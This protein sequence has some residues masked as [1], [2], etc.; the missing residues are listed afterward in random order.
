[1]PQKVANYNV[2]RA[3]YDL[4]IALFCNISPLYCC[5]KKH[6]QFKQ[7]KN[8]KA[9]NFPISSSRFSFRSKQDYPR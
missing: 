4:H 5:R 2:T 6:L 7:N 3:K 9:N 8:E 1:M